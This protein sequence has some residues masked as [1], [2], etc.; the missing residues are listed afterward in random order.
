MGWCHIDIMTLFLL[1]TSDFMPHALYMTFYRYH[2]YRFTCRC[3][4]TATTGTPT[5]TQTSPGKSTSPVSR[6]QVRRAVACGFSKGNG[7]RKGYCTFR[8]TVLTFRIKD[9]IFEFKKKNM[10]TLV[11]MVSKEK[12][13]LWQRALS[14]VCKYFFV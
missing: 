14:V 9:N 11:I 1:L 6:Y 5:F 12:V 2:V 4:S 3:W 8:F 13:Y 7:A 10:A